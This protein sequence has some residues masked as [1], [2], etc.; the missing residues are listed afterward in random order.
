MS[1]YPMLI[2]INYTL[3][4]TSARKYTLFFFIRSMLCIIFRL[5]SFMGHSKIFSGIS[6][7]VSRVPIMV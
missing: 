3:F 4:V 5:I 1:D 7:W 2:S 6:G